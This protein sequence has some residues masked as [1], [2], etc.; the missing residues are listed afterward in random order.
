MPRLTPAA[1]MPRECDKSA[2]YLEPART[3][4]RP[5]DCAGAAPRGS[6]WN[7]RR[8]FGGF[9]TDSPA[10]PSESRGRVLTRRA[11]PML[12][13]MAQRLAR[14]QKLEKSSPRLVSAYSWS[15]W[16]Y[17][18]TGAMLLLCLPSMPDTCMSTLICSTRAFALT[19]VLQARTCVCVPCLIAR[20]RH[21]PA[22]T[23]YASRRGRAPTP[24]MRSQPLAGLCR[25]AGG[26][27]RGSTGAW[28]GST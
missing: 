22:A 18:L 2:M 19:L 27:G 12:A 28:R 21:G 23:P 6:L 9:W 26:R 10:T 8:I 1:N 5:R 13:T 16:A 3:S 15:C 14:L 4:T 25:A 7:L 11:M 24:T 20:R 17:S